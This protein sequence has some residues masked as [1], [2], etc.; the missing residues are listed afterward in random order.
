M[1]VEGSEVEFAGDQEDDR[2]DGRQSS[3]ASGLALGRL[4]QSVER[5][6]EAVGHARSCPGDDALEVGADH[7]GHGIHRL[8]FRA[9]DVGA[10]LCEHRAHDVDLFSTEDLPEVLTVLPGACRA[11]G[12]QM[13]QQGIQISSAGVADTTGILQQRPAQPLE[14]RVSLLLGA[15]GQIQRV[16]GMGDDVELVEGDRGVWQVLGH[17][18]I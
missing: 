2:A 8:D 7:F 10:P 4:E 1:G 15:A 9:H 17:P 13:D 18:L 16:R 5:F 3:I 6:E 12:G 11:F 14:C